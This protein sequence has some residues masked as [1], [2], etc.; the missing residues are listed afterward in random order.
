MSRVLPPTFQQVGSLADQTLV[1]AMAFYL[2]GT[3]VDLNDREACLKL[4]RRPPYDK[5][6][7]YRIIDAVLQKAA[8]IRSQT[9]V[10]HATL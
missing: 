6:P 1:P 2:E 3:G 7:L 9:R 10:S 8:E 5:A 4:L